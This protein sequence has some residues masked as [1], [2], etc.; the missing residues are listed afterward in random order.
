VNAVRWQRLSARAE[1]V[2]AATIAELPPEIRAEASH[3]P[4]LFQPYC[5]DDPDLLGTYGHFTAG[6]ISPANGPIT[7]YLAAIDEYCR[8]EG[9]DFDDEVRIT[10]LH[11]L[12]HHLGWD[13][14]DLEERGLG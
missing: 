5:E 8:D 10:F 7:L 9:T 4:C 1:R 12:G 2:V 11:E 3:V 6:E 14:G 13:E